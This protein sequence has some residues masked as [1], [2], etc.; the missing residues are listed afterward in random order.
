MDFTTPVPERSGTPA[1]RSGPSTLGRLARASL[2]KAKADKAVRHDEILQSLMDE[3][4]AE[5]NPT[6]T[7]FET[8]SPADL[9]K[10]CKEDKKQYLDKYL[11]WYATDA[12]SEKATA[13]SASVSLNC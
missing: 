2:A 4:E 10:M 7:E 3:P 1:Q 6:K 11:K 13:G 8:I 5:N 12:S 9:I